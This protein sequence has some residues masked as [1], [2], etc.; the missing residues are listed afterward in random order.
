MQNL[1]FD[2]V[3]KEFDANP[4]F[5]L[6]QGYTPDKLQGIC[7]L[8]PWQVAVGR[9]LTTAAHPPPRA[10]EKQTM[11]SETQ[12]HIETEKTTTTQGKIGKIEANLVIETESETGKA[13]ETSGG[14]NE[15]GER[16]VA[17]AVEVPTDLV[18]QKVG[19]TGSTSPKHEVT[20]AQINLQQN[21]IARTVARRPDHQS[22]S[23]DI[24]DP[25]HAH[26]LLSATA[27]TPPPVTA[28]HHQRPQGQTTTEIRTTGDPGPTPQTQQRSR[29]L[30]HA[31]ANRP[32]P[33]NPP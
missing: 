27:T 6:R 14:A 25:V 4:S 26:D 16:G 28:L 9:P 29:R 11:R 5:L 30:P 1:L 33:R 32:P 8:S 24:P 31:R 18:R 7:S 22:D 15:S 12:E 19:R 13:T 20:L 10:N 17:H 21:Q 2:L 23:A 3:L